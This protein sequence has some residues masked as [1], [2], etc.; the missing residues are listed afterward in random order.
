[1]KKIFFTACLLVIALMPSRAEM[2]A[3]LYSNNRLRYFDS[4]APATFVKTVEISGIPTTET[5]VAMDFHPAGQ[6]FVLT[7]E[8]GTLRFYDINQDT[9]VATKGSMS[10]GGWDVGTGFGFEVVPPRVANGPAR[11]VVIS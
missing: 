4:E 10:V 3:A 5:V 6:L 7:R 8:S 9:G 1:M 11:C 2:I